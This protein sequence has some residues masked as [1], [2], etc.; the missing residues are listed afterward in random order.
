[1]V[2]LKTGGEEVGIGSVVAGVNVISDSSGG[3]N[4]VSNPILGEVLEVFDDSFVLMVCFS[5]F[6]L[7]ELG[8]VCS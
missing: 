3:V 7:L 8:F 2:T 4:G 5:V 6:V 1:M